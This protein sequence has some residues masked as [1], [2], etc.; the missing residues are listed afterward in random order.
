M[1][2]AIVTGNTLKG[3][4]ID[5]NQLEHRANRRITNWSIVAVWAGV[6]RGAI[7]NCVTDHP[8]QQKLRERLYEL[9]LAKIAEAKAVPELQNTMFNQPLTTR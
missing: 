9:L 2:K 7:S 5:L 6:T 4:L 8:H 1:E 3:L